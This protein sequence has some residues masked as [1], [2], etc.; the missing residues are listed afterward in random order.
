MRFFAGGARSVRGFR[1]QSLGPR[2]E[3]GNVI[4]GNKLLTASV[5][6]EFNF[7]EKWAAALFFDTGNAMDRWSVGLRD[8]AGVGLRW[9]SPVGPV[10]LDVARPVDG[11]DE[12]IQWHL[13]IGPDL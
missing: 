13:E 2:D 12:G 7:L 6:L 8:G 3:N 10:R 4:G 11:G 5:Q 9:N 1:Y